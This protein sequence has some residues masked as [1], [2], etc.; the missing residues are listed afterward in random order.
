VTNTHDLFS[1]GLE[2]AYF[3][4]KEIEV[5]IADCHYSKVPKKNLM[6]QILSGFIS[7]P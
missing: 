3:T 7:H 1:V 4:P 2:A 5:I 6:N